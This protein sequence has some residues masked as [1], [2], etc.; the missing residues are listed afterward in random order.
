MYPKSHRQAHLP[1]LQ[2][3]SIRGAQ[4]RLEGPAVLVDRVV[5][6]NNGMQVAVMSLA[7]PA[8]HITAKEVGQDVFD[9]TLHS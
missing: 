9:V 7:A 8:V 6:L 4:V 2:I 1:L 5:V 3:T